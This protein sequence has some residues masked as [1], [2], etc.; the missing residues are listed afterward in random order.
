[1]AKT[2]LLPTATAVRMVW[3]L[4]SRFSDDESSQ[5]MANYTEDTLKRIE[6]QSQGQAIGA[7]ERSYVA[8]AVAT[9]K[10][11]LRSLETVYKGRTLNFSEN[12]KLRTA[13]LDSVKE[14]LNFGSKAKDFLNSLPAMT[15]GA[16]GGVTLAHLLGISETLMWGI[17]LV[18]AALG[19]MVNWW[20]VR[21][22]RERTQM[23][24]V[25]QDY[26]RSLYYDQYIRRVRSILH[27]LFLDL[28]R[29]HLRVFQENCEP[30]VGPSRV[31]G[32]IHDILAGVCPTLCPYAHKHMRE[33]KILPDLWALC[34]SGT[35]E[36]VAKCPHWEGDTQQG[37]RP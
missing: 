9:M 35:P 8:A 19:Y 2:T 7:E 6:D 1:M 20:F 24:Y 4:T 17:G 12:E 28:E 37:L 32:L 5:T 33:K 27:G 25:E 26:D 22:A 11:S 31:E 13:Y 34:E 14:S 18:L 36:A 29:I 30:D 23:L 15:V 16:A 10:A 3:A 21:L